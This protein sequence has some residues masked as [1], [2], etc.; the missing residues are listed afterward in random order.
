MTTHQT[1]MTKS[2]YNGWHAETVIPMG[3]VEI[4][5]LGEKKLARRVLE[6]STSKRR[7]GLISSFASV[8]TI[9]DQTSSD[10]NSYSIRTIEIFSG[11][12][13]HF[14]ATPAK[15]ATEKAVKEAHVKALEH[16]DTFLA[17]AIA[18]YAAKAA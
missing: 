1:T 8:A 4:T 7:P 16:A 12:A 6:I 2:A 3:T 14:N 11:Y 9:G 5:S 15:T 10:G 17:E 13:K 18:H